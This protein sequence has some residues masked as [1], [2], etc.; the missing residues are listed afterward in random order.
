[1]THVIE[2]HKT[3][4][5]KCRLDASVYNDKQRWNNDKYRCECKELIAKFKCGNGF[6]RNPS[7]CKSECD[8]SCDLGEYLDYENCKCRERLTDKL[9][10]E[11]SEDIDG[12]E[13]VYNVTLN[14]NEKV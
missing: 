12:N 5:C 6:I 7:I 4:K 9:D 3:R 11:S 2:L 14:D 1:M 8:K 10:E 13:M